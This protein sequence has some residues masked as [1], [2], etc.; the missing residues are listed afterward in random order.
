PQNNESLVGRIRERITNGKVEIS[1]SA[2]DTA[3][4]AMVPSR[5]RS[6]GYKPLFRECLDWIAE[7]Q[8]P[9][10]SWGL[11]PCRPDSIK[12]SLSST[13]ACVLALHKWGVHS[14]L[15]RRG[16][17]FMA[18]NA[19]AA[20]DKH[21][22]S[23]IGFDVTFAGMIKYAKELDLN[24]PLSPVLVDSLLGRIQESQMRSRNLEYV[25]EGF[26]SSCNWEAVIT[27]CQRSNGSLFNSPATTAAALVHR[28]DDK[29]LEY[30]TSAVEACKG[31]VPT[32]YPVDV[33]SRLSVV[34]MFE[35]LGIDG[36]FAD[37]L[38][39]VLDRLYRQWQVKDEE[40]FSDITCLALAFRLLRTKGYDVSSEELAEYVE[41]E[42]LLSK[43]GGAR[44]CRLDAVFELY[45]GSKIRVLEEE[46]FLERI[47]SWTGAFLQEQ[48]MDFTGNFDKH[49]EKQL[50]YDLKNFHGNLDAVRNRRSV[51]QLCAQDFR[52]LKTAYRCP[53]IHNQDVTSLS[54]RHFRTSQAQYR[55]ELE[56][57]QRWFS[58]CRLD[59]LQ[60]G[61][62][63]FHISYFATAAAIVGLDLSAAR[64]RYAQSV[65]LISCIDDFFDHYGSKEEALCIIDLV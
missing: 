26:G 32:M 6:G 14:R 46:G 37:E 5:D 18:A 33:F 44:H 1:S 17:D 19:S 39:A 62:K 22:I 9:D 63:I 7:N 35:R 31:S 60:R 40:M 49:F 16:L 65:V 56:D 43:V 34:D 11:N 51:E 38:N 57:M 24:L 58:D 55:E 61:R 41:K 25:A 42:N 10:G 8:N 15:A 28:H 45:R 52:V 36:Y 54:V 50:E 64:V 27:S 21:R 20:M 48:Q 29:C 47:D 4:V 30:L 2:Y 53:M 13:L 3:W 12:D 59:Q 23:P